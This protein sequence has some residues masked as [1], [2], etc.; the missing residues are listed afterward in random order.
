MLIDTH[1]HLDYADF[2]TDFGAVLAR[3]HAAGVEQILTIGTS[4]ASSRRA[5][6]LAAEH[7]AVHAVVGIHPTSVEEA[8]DEDHAALR[9][10]AGRSRVVA[11]G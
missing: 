7:A 8:T 6:E 3:A 5:T 1:A 4:A 10:I 9:E 11:I 2:A